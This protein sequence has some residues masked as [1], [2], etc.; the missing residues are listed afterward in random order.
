M[1]P[2]QDQYASTT[3]STSS[4]ATWVPDDSDG[5]FHH[6]D[7]PNT[8]GNYLD[9]ESGD[10][11]FATASTSDHLSSGKLW[12]PAHVETVDSGTGYVVAA[13]RFATKAIPVV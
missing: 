10:H 9:S 13:K 7:N 12:P 3:W 8:D 6:V 11:A 4:A 2:G 5:M 1:V